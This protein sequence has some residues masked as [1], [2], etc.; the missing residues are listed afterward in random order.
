MLPRIDVTALNLIKPE[1]DV[2]LV[3][4][5]GALSTFVEDNANNTPLAESVEQMEQ[6]YGALRLVDI[7]GAAELA[8]V[9]FALLR[10]VN[11]LQEKT[12]DIY[13]SAL[14]SG[15]MVL[16]RYLEYVQIKA[17]NL[18]QLLIPSI[19]EARAALGV[20]PLGEG[21]FLDVPYL[22]DNNIVEPLAIDHA[23]AIVLAKRIRLMYQ[24]GTINLLKDQAQPVHFRLMRR[25]LER[26]T[27]LCTG[28]PLALL[29]WVGEAALEAFS[30]GVELNPA[31]KQL[32]AQLEQQLKL[33]VLPQGV[34]Q[35]VEM[36]VLANSLAVVGLG[37]TGAKVEEVQRAFDLTS[38]CISQT[39]L[40]IQSNTMFGPGGSVIKTVATVLKDEITNI[41]EILDVIARGSRNNDDNDEENSYESV[42]ASI[43][44]ASQT[45]IM[46]SLNDVA[47]AMRQQSIIVSK[48]TEI[49]SENA[50]NTLFDV[51]LQA[52]NSVATLDREMTPGAQTVINNTRISLHQLDEARSFL[53]QETRNGLS[54]IKRS[55]L[56]YIESNGEDPMHLSNIPTTL[57]SSS[58]GLEFLGV[59]RG[60]VIL[61]TTVAFVEAWVAN[62]KMPNMTIIEN[63]ADV[64]ACVDYFL[65]SLEV[66]KPISENVF[67]IAEDALAE[68]GYPVPK[69]QAA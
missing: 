24:I 40:K 58:G 38:S 32:L 26:A 69:Q 2:S 13:Y 27:Q 11:E 39:Q 42:A 50:L 7:P 44:K 43:L 61:R 15:M 3:Q 36:T 37:E 16:G 6:V 31:R 46:L 41:K 64:I 34:S 28:K 14:G 33:L 45:L 25:A 9:L 56:S 10:Q 12:P 19:N 47:T 8:E 21:Y 29:W 23:Q 68:L 17:V 5:E 63:F 49:P 35:P 52:D 20:A 60:A 51:L 1:V 66:N 4:I 65:E 54:L 48:W 67:D 62:K 22:P 18:P 59:P 30:Q 55:V 57:Q 53:V